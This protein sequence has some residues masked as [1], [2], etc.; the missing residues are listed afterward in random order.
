ML[1]KSFL[2]ITLGLVA[3]GVGS[4]L[5]GCKKEIVQAPLVTFFSPKANQSFGFG[6]TIWVD[7]SISHPDLQKVTLTLVNVDFQPVEEVVNISVKGNSF[8]LQHYIIIKNKSIESGKYFVRIQVIAQGE[9]FNNFA[10]VNVFALQKQRLAVYAAASDGFSQYL[11]RIENGSKNLSQTSFGDVSAIAINS[12]YNRIFL[13]PEYLGNLRLYAFPNDSLLWQD[14]NNAS[15]GARFMRGLYAAENDV[16][17]FYADGR[18]VRFGNNGG[19]NFVIQMPI[20]FQ[21]IDMLKAENYLLVVGENGPQ[22]EKALFYFNETTGALIRKIELLGDKEHIA[23]LPFDQSTVAVLYNDANGKATWDG[24]QLNGIFVNLPLLPNFRFTAAAYVQNGQMALGT[25][26]G[27]YQFKYSPLN[28]L[29]I[30]PVVPS[31]LVYDALNNQ[32]LVGAG[33]SLSLRSFPAMQIVW[34]Q[35]FTAPLNGV[36][37]LYNK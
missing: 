27:I 14:A 10:E 7:A 34:A 24:Y 8:S 17:G 11:Y 20:G 23:L 18:V 35:S 22:S 21:A 13:A 36:S 4:A 16:Y 12:L 37:V 29:P 15:N 33:S 25:D 26:L 32:L 6:D 3:A 28:F 9:S 2:L 1:I 5:I 30:S 19:L 31:I